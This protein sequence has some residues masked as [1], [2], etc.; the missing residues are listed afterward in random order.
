MINTSPIG[1]VWCSITGKA[2]TRL[3]FSSVFLRQVESVVLF[4]FT[5]CCSLRNTTILMHQGL[6]WESQSQP[7]TSVLLRQLLSSQPNADETRL[8]MSIAMP[9]LELP[10]GQP[11][12]LQPCSNQFRLMKSIAMAVRK[13]IINTNKQQNLLLPV[14]GATI[15]RRLPTDITLVVAVE[16][17]RSSKDRK[18]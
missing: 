17:E 4:L 3:G 7:G 18:K 14:V 5:I 13:T 11:T 12:V 2:H 6:P 1:I 16:D 10:Y 15:N 8:K 9:L